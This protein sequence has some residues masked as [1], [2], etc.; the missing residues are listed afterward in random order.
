[1]P[2]TYVESVNHLKEQDTPKAFCE[3][4]KNHTHLR[5]HED[6]LKL[7]YSPYGAGDGQ[8]HH[9]QKDSRG[10]SIILLNNQKF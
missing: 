7:T 5:L 3:T 8:N 4:S 10:I 1:M 6:P 9:F 2:P